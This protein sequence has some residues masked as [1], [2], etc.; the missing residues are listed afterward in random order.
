MLCAAAII[1]AATNL[2][3]VVT[4]QR[5]GLPFFFMRDTA[6]VHW[7]VEQAGGGDGG[8]SIGDGVIVHGTREPSVKHRIV[9]THLATNAAP[10]AV[11]APM[12]VTIHGIFD[13]VLPYG[14]SLWYGRTLA[15]EGLLRDINRRQATTQLLVGV[16]AE[17]I[18]VEIPIPIE[19]ALPPD[20][21]LGAT[22]RVVGAL[23]YTSI[24]NYSAGVFGRVENVELI[25]RTVEDVTVVRSAPFWTVRRLVNLIASLLAVFLIVFAWAITLRRMVAKRTRE[26]GESIRQRAR[27]KIEA[28]AARRERLRL[29][30]DLHDGFQQYLAGATFR[31]KAALNYLPPDAAESREQLEKVRLALQ[32]TQNGLRTT[33]WA[34]NEESE[35]PESLLELF[36]FAA[37]RMAHWDGIVEIHS[38]GTE[39]QIARTFAGTL[40]LILQE[41]VGNAIRHGAASKVRVTVNFTEK[42]LEIAVS[43][44]GCGFEASAESP[45]GHFG[46]AGMRRRTADLGG[47]MTIESAKGRGTTLRFSFPF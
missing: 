40:L 27:A 8:V 22:V 28:D 10:S 16:D 45:A 29:A 38:T 14:D 33:L 20:L 25:P 1:A 30:A 42:T 13:E 19:E 35:G 46:I 18:Q 2:A 43:D 34:M 7:R 26:L 12:A 31:L 23:A 9:A 4:F 39:R 5:D 41:A 37:R 6:G 15:A 32:H 17:N 44:D 24:E 47:T 11:P 36:R 21:R 3:G